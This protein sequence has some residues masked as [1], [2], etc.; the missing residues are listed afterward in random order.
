MYNSTVYHTVFKYISW[1]R[2]KSGRREKTSEEGDF[3]NFHKR[4]G[5]RFSIA[6]YKTED[7]IW[8][9]FQDC[10]QFKSSNVWM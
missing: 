4:S 5:H 10:I 7:Q 2:L 9:H 3:G 1:T 6:E 8:S